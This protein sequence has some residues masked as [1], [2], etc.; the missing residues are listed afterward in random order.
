MSVILSLLSPILQQDNSISLLPFNR[1]MKMKK[2]SGFTLIEVLIA[3]VILSFGLL[4]LA[5]LQA[6]SLRNNLSAYH[7]SQATQ[8]AYDMADRMRANLADAGTYAASTYS[9][10]APTAATQQAGCTTV[11]NPCASAAMAQQDL[12]EWNRNIIGGPATGGLPLT[13]ATLPLGQG[14]ITVAAPPI[15]QISVNWDD[16]RDGLRNANFQINFEL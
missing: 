9:T 5:G 8:L 11:A 15:Y 2:Q 7:R 10:V 13:P 6:T 12:F 14:L 16:N 1:N 4:G 3:L